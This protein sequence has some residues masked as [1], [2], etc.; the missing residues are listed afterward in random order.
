MVRGSCGAPVR[1]RRAEPAPSGIPA[2]TDRPSASAPGALDDDDAGRSQAADR[3]ATRRWRWPSRS[4]AAAEHRAYGR[5]SMPVTMRVW[6]GVEETRR[7]PV[8]PRVGLTAGER[9]TRR[10]QQEL[11][12]ATRATSCVHRSAR[13]RRAR[14]A[15][16]RGSTPS[17]AA[18]CRRAT[19]PARRPRDLRLTRASCAGSPGL[20]WAIGETR[21]ALR[22][23]AG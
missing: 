23:A 16:V 9:G 18:A 8:D 11:P 5:A 7:S 13:V 21:L 22:A 19:S 6:S 3:A 10:G 17:R 20:L 12:R 14:R 15:L 2:R 4:R 1:P